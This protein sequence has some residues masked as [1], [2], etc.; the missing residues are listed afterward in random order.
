MDILAKCLLQA[1]AKNRAAEGL[2]KLTVDS[3]IPYLLSDLTNAISHEMGL[4]NKAT[5]TAPFMRLK[6]KIDELKA[7]PRYQFMFSGM[8][9]A[10]TMADF[11]AKIF[12]LPGQG[13]ADLDH[14]RL[15]RAVRH[16]L[17]RRRGAVAPGVRL[18]DLVARAKCSGR[19]CSS[20][21]KRT[22]TSPPTRTPTG[23]AVAQD[24]RADRQ[25][26]PQI[27]RLARP[28]HPAPVG[29]G[30]RRALAMRHDHLDAPQ[31]RPR[32]GVREVGDARRRARLPRFDPG[33]AQPRMHHLRRGRLDPDPRLVRRSRARPRP[34]SS[35]PLFSELWQQTGDEEAMVGRVVKRWRAQGR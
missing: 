5:D 16:H 6:T 9:V 23:Q 33:A 32:P 10:D 26:R 11:I 31:Q 22:A 17:G 18:C 2:A 20:A 19:S 27:R 4:L 35:D 12:R 28:D 13:Q 30:R 1:R 15:G 24:P 8:L 3:P 21:R 29:P 34:A 14:R 7:D 25:G